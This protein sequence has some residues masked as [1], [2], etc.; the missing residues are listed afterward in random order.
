VTA[1]ER[2]ALHNGL[3]NLVADA[4][5]ALRL[6]DEGADAATIFER[7]SDV[8]FDAAKVVEAADYPSA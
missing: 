6:V 5:D 4:T 8:E 7:I 3:S 1:A 2:Q